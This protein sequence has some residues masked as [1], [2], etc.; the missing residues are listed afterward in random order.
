[1]EED[2]KGKPAM[3]ISGM[4]ARAKQRVLNR[5]GKRTSESTFIFKR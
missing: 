4:Y 3:M 5:I 2:R 1:M